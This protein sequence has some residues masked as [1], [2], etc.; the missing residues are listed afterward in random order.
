MQQDNLFEALQLPASS[1]PTAY[2]AWPGTD[3]P[4]SGMLIGLRTYIHDLVQ[5]LDT[6]T[7]PSRLHPDHTG[8]RTLLQTYYRC[9]YAQRIISA[10]FDLRLQ[11]LHP[12]QPDTRL[13]C[14]PHATAMHNTS[15]IEAVCQLYRLTSK[16]PDGLQSCMADVIS[17]DEQLQRTLHL[18]RHEANS[19]DIHQP[20][21]A[22]DLPL[23]NDLI[24][25]LRQSRPQPRPSRHSR[26]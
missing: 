5:A 3:G 25:K 22:H 12:P 20:S 26:R 10:L 4:W 21:A 7:E 18:L 16:T 13:I 23:L 15:G 9:P 19:C 2:P 11:H 8:F 1:P 14:W 6:C 24:T 17:Q